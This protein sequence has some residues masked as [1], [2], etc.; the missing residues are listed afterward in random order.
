MNK[1]LSVIIIDGNIKLNFL[2]F[3]VA[4]VIIRI[5]M[6]CFTAY[7]SFD[8]EIERF[9]DSLSSLRQLLANVNLIIPLF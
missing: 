9:Q 7:M 3:E 5:A 2:F 1:F 6:F 8:P 4:L